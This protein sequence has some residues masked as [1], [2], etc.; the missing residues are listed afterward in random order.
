MRKL[1][2]AALFLAL[3]LITACS[4]SDDIA[5]SQTQSQIESN[6]VGTWEL[7]TFDKGWAQVS[8]F[9][10]REVTLS[11]SKHGLL[12]ITN[13]TSTDLSPLPYSGTCPFSVNKEHL[14]TINGVTLEYEV[15]GTT[16]RL[17]K[18]IEA[19]GICIILT[20]IDN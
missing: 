14:V 3:G 1:L 16:L 20:N 19:D 2:F 12:T 18:D 9:N 8:S 7:K 5:E 17:A 4:S 15:N 11:F 10:S 6:I 13:N